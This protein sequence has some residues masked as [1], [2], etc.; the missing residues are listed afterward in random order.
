MRKLLVLGL[1]VAGLAGC[2]TNCRQ[3]SEKLC[4]CAL[5]T[6]DKNT[7]LQRASQNEGANPPSPTDEQNCAALLPICDCHLVDTAQG[8]ANCGLARPL[9]NPDAGF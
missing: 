4:D 6:T 2:K 7:C 5:N 1:V 8:K 3:L 9:A